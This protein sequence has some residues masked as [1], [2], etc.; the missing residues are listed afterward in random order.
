MVPEVAEELATEEVDAFAE[1]E[2]GRFVRGRGRGAG[3][4][5]AKP[6]AEVVVRAVSLIY[7]SSAQFSARE[8]KSLVRDYL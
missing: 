7:F 8:K 6:A 4:R 2:G 5:D 3:R 1:V